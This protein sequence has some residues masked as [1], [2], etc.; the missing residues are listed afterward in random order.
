ML[1]SATLESQARIRRHV[2]A[3]QANQ[4]QPW[5]KPYPRRIRP[6]GQVAMCFRENRLGNHAPKLSSFLLMAWNRSEHPDW[7]WLP[8]IAAPESWSYAI[9]SRTQLKPGN[10][11]R[12]RGGERWLLQVAGYPALHHGRFAAGDRELLAR[13]VEVALNTKEGRPPRGASSAAPRRWNNP[14]TLVLTCSWPTFVLIDVLLQCIGRL[15]RHELLRPTGFSDPK[16]VVLIPEQGLDRLRD[17]PPPPPPPEFDNGLG[18][19]LDEGGAFHGIC[20]DLVISELTRRLVARRSSWTIPD[21]S[22]SLVEMAIHSECRDKQLEE[23]GKAWKKYDRKHG[24]AE[25]A[26]G[27]FAQLL[28]L[29][30]EEPDGC[31]GDTADEYP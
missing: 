15:H 24:G 6:S 17:P 14:W 22:R 25:A 29:D 27:Q 31:Q 20:R 21:M 5:S 9:P 23:T 11:V 1:T 30:R 10:E 18:G 16:C 4:I 28:W 19:W 26:E 3:G 2:H 8:P 7:G 13:A 12:A